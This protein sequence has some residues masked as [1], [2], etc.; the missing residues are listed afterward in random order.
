M[1]V[2]SRKAEEFVQI[3]E[4]I[5]VKVIKTASGSVKIGIDAPGG[6]RVLRGELFDE[7]DDACAPRTLRSMSER[8]ELDGVPSMEA[9]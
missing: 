3:G 5:I 9:C 6:V 2:L 1:L 4:N 8:V 7:V